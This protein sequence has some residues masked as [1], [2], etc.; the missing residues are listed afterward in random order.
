MKTVILEPPII[1]EIDTSQ[2]Q[3][4]E[5]DWVRDNLIKEN[6]SDDCRS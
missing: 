1:I 3:A 6:E 2:E 4:L 5:I